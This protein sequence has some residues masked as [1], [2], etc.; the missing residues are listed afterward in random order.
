MR[1]GIWGRGIAII[2]LVAATPGAAQDRDASQG[3]P[4]RD[5]GVPGDRLPGTKVPPPPGIPV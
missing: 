1:M 3:S 5:V 2:S 4:G